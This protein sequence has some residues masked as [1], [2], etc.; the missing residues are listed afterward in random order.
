MHDLLRGMGRGIQEQ[1]DNNR[2]LWLPMGA[3]RNLSRDR[4]EGVNMLVYTG[5]NGREPISVHRMPSLRYLVLQN[6]KVV[7]N[8]GNLAPNLLWIKI[9]N[10]GF[11][12]QH[13][14][15][16]SEEVQCLL[17]LPRTSE[18][19]ESSD[20]REAIDNIDILVPVFS[21]SFVESIMCVRMPLSF[22]CAFA[23]IRGTMVTNLIKHGES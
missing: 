2:R 6:T 18:D 23:P 8:I 13:R 10:S 16:G 11:K 20:I 19:S 5:E 22:L 7:G 21:K 3:H 14:K 17:Y 12:D 15:L 4:A 1:V 9:R